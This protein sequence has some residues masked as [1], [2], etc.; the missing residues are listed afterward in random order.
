MLRT[1]GNEKIAY[2][3]G[4][5]VSIDQVALLLGSACDPQV[6]IEEFLKSVLKWLLKE[7]H[8]LVTHYFKSERLYS[9]LFGQSCWQFSWLVR[10]TSRKTSAFGSTIKI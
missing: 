9:D 4:H 7:E 6:A 5:S 3:S 2:I 10:N 1:C 8:E